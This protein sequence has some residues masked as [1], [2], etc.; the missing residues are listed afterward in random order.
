MYEVQRE[1]DVEGV[2]LRTIEGSVFEAEDKRSFWHR[3]LC[4]V[5]LDGV[6]G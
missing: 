6:A 5:W 1:I 4:S 2:R 3:D